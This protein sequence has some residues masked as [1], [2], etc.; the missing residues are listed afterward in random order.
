MR[1][2]VDHRALT[3]LLWSQVMVWHGV[4]GGPHYLCINASWFLQRRTEKNMA[5]FCY[6]SGFSPLGELIDSIL[7]WS[8]GFQQKPCFKI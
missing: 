7:A 2:F 3:A 5:L 6:L 1:G 8:S 4:G